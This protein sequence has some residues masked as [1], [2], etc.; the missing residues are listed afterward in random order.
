MWTL[1]TALML[2][3]PTAIA[4]ETETIGEAS[5]SFS[6][7]RLGMTLEG[8]L[9]A[10]I[11]MLEKEDSLLF[12]DTGLK[13]LGVASTNPAFSRAG[14]RVVFSPLAIVDLTGHGG[15]STYFGN[16]QTVIG[17]TDPSENYGDNAAMKAYVEDTDNR[18]KGNG[19][20]AGGALT[21]KAKAGPMVI[22]VHT[23]M[24]HWDVDA[25]VEGD[26]FFE[27]EQEL[28]LAL[29]G[30]QVLSINGV[31]LYEL[32]SDPSDERFFRI[33]NLTT[34]RTSMAAEDELLRTG[35][36]AIWQQGTHLSHTLLVQPYLRDRGFSTAMPPF[37]AYVLKY[38]H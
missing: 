18:A 27:R 31:F 25:K 9:G 7:W 17:Y 14:A 6:Y 34:R 33:G 8:K 36:L 11:P 1:L 21:L 19:W 12:Q 23:D 16:F 30:D 35:L 32:D 29:R 26:W 28:M 2:T 3:Q 20:H 10:R 37:T 38:T 24:T 22:L 13:L 15:V 4:S 5:L